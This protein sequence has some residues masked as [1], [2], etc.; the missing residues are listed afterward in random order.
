[1]SKSKFLATLFPASKIF[2]LFEFSWATCKGI[3]SPRAISPRTQGRSQ[4]CP[5][6]LG[7]RSSDTRSTVSSMCI[8]SR[9]IGRIREL[10][11]CL[12]EHQYFRN[13]DE[14][15][16]SIR[17]VSR[18]G[19]HRISTPSGMGSRMKVLENVGRVGNREGGVALGSPWDTSITAAY[20]T[21]RIRHHDVCMASSEGFL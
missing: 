3:C 15:K 11:F 1:M 12:N 7:P 8:R 16:V 17:Q 5:G 19:F 9:V 21:P 4:S 20:D 18:Y 14:C 2:M 10:P 6:T 13:C